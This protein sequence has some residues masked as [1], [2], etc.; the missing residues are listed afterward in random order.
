MYPAAYPFVILTAILASLLLGRRGGNQLRMP[1]RERWGIL[2]GAFVGAMLGAKLPFVLSDWHGL[3]DGSAWFTN[4]KTILTGLV[5]G[6]LGVELAKFALGIQVKTGDR[7]AVPVA[8]AVAIGRLGCLLAGCCFGAPTAGVWG[9]DFGDGI[10]RHPVQL[11]EFTFHLGAAILLEY[12]QRRGLFQGQLFK[13]YILL[14]LAFRF[15]TEFLRPEV[16]LWLGLTG[17]QWC[18]F[19]IAPVFLWLWHRDAQRRA[20]GELLFA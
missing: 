18:C 9:V 8:V 7:F 4:G 10:R 13:L 6:Y 2:A 17:Y 11:Y 15:L 14:Y 16:P 12:L 20:A 5:G 19:A 3:I 1:S